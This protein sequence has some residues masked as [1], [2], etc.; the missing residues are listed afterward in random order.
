[1]LEA[2]PRD[3]LC[4]LAKAYGLEPD[5]IGKPGKA[6]A[7]ERKIG[8]LCEELQRLRERFDERERYY[9]AAAAAARAAKKAKAAGFSPRGRAAAADD[10]QELTTRQ[11]LERKFAELED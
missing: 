4:Y 1:M 6:D 8:L 5:F 9:A 10:E 2:S 3:T 7:C 11:I